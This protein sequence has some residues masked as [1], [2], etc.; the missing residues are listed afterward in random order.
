MATT[1]KIIK[2]GKF[3]EFEHCLTNLWKKGRKYYRLFGKG[4][5]PNGC[6]RIAPKMVELVDICVANGKDVYG[7]EEIEFD[8]CGTVPSCHEVIKY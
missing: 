5:T 4:I 1:K 3:S 6:W 8:A 2:A 7:E